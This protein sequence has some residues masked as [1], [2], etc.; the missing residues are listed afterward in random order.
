MRWD[1]D[2]GCIDAICPESQTSCCRSIDSLSLFTAAFGISTR[3][4]SWHRVPRRVAIIGLP[5]SHPMSLVTSGTLGSLRRPAGGLRRSGS[6]TRAMHGA[7][8]S[9]LK[10]SATDLVPWVAE[11]RCGVEKRRPYPGMDWRGLT[12]RWTPCPK[13]ERP[14]MTW[15]CRLSCCGGREQT[16]SV[17]TQ[18]ATELGN[19]KGDGNG[20]RTLRHSRSPDKSGCFGISRDRPR[21]R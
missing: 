7:F 6:A 10:R 13:R 4:A 18:I 11:P 9:G 14:R 8:T 21:W 2:F 19:T 15:L 16:A 1:F 3:A 12:S 20:R 17:A 5:S